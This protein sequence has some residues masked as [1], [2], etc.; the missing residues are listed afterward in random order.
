[1]IIFSNACH[2]TNILFPQKVHNEKTPQKCNFK[3]SLKID[4]LSFCL[5][6]VAARSLQLDVV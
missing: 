5:E 2:T 6:A 4:F 1:M 3:N